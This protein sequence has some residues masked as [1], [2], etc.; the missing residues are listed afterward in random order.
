MN[1]STDANTWGTEEEDDLPETSQ[2]P[3]T[4]NAAQ[5]EEEEEPTPWKPNWTD[6]EVD[7]IT[8]AVIGGAIAGTTIIDDNPSDT[9]DG[10]PNNSPDTPFNGIFGDTTHGSFDIELG[11]DELF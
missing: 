11:G 3:S 8:A 2:N 5:I 10:E 7:T 1:P 6:D 9:P 4:T